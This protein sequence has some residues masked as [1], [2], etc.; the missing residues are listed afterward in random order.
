MA[1]MRRARPGWPDL[2]DA[3]DRL[4]EGEGEKSW[5]RVEEYVDGQT[6]VVRAEMPGVDPDK[7]VDIS[8]VDGKLHIT[9][10]REEKDEQKEKDTYRS[11]FRYGSFSRIVP[12]PAG[13]T[14]ADV[15]ASYTDGVLEIR[16]PL[17]DVVQP[18]PTKVQV[19]RG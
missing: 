16:V 2:Q 17:A 5:L 15:T 3:F 4:F 18:T 12:L 14:E 19:T 7:D 10:S 11:E 9:A 13:A 1:L 8:I 6:H